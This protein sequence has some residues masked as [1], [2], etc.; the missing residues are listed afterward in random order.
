M[1][2]KDLTKYLASIGLAGLLVSGG[3]HALPGA[4]HASS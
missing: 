1:D 4:V 2:R 3:M